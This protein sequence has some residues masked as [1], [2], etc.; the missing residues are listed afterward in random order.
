VVLRERNRK[1]GGENVFRLE[2]FYTQIAFRK[3][4]K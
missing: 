2:Y 1:V 4:T 3:E